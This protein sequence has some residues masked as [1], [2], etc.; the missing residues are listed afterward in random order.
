MP[1]CC[2]SRSYCFFFFFFFRVT[3][4]L[5]LI[6]SSY[7]SARVFCMFFFCLDLILLLQTF[8][9]FL[10]L[11]SCLHVVVRKLSSEFMTFIL[12]SV[13]SIYTAETRDVVT[14]PTGN[15]DRLTWLRLNNLGNRSVSG[16]ALS[17]PMLMRK[18][19]RQEVT[20]DVG[21]SAK[22]TIYHHNRGWSAV[23][24]LGIFWIISL[25]LWLMYVLVFDRVPQIVWN[26]AAVVTHVILGLRSCRF[27]T[28]FRIKILY[29]LLV[30]SMWTLY[31]VRWGL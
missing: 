22:Y 6:L 17:Q 12:G 15:E 7:S 28:G 5:S 9:R 31:P 26:V 3:S 20:N 19:G 16:L 21:S 2:A 14:V 1:V 11:L 30:T 4:N 18:A 13:F 25:N 10:K 29:L 23:Y 8:P 27:K 24:M